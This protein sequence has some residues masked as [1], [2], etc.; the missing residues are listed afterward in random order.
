[1][2]MSNSL[3]LLGKSRSERR[4]NLNSCSSL[5]EYFLIEDGDCF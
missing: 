3:N 1:M 5:G 4:D 2:I